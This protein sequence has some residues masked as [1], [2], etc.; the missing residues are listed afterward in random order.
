MDSG[1][2]QEIEKAT[3][4]YKKNGIVTRKDVNSMDL[5]SAAKKINEALNENGHEH[6]HMTMIYTKNR[7]DYSS[8]IYNYEIYSYKEVEEYMLNYVLYE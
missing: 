1:L 2:Q 8:V 6:A 4:I 7:L 3:K 5:Y